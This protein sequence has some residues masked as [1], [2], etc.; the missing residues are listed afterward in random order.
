M[1]EKKPRNLTEEEVM[2]I[3]ELI[4]TMSIKEISTH[5]GVHERSINYWIKTLRAK[6]VE[7]KTKT[8]RRPTLSI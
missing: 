1:Q 6:N 2:Q 5:F 7:V 8:G 4:K 3:P